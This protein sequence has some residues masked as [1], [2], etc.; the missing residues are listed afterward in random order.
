MPNLETVK[1]GCEQADVLGLSFS[2][3]QQDPGLI[4]LICRVAKQEIQL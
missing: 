3:L 2:F 4:D 1:V